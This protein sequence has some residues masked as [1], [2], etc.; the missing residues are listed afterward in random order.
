MGH[1]TTEFAT[2]GVGDVAGDSCGNI[3]DGA[4]GASIYIRADLV[5]EAWVEGDADEREFAV[6]VGVGVERADGPAERVAG[7]LDE[8]IEVFCFGAPVGE[9]FEDGLDVADGDAL[10]EE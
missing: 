5:F 4:G 10:A 6:V 7:V 8:D 3:E 2:D 9:G 1:D